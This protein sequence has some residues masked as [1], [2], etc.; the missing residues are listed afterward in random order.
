MAMNHDHPG[1]RATSRPRPLSPDLQVYRPTLT[2][3][4]SIA[5]RTTGV[6]LYIGL[7]GLVG[8]LAAV[9]IGPNAYAS[10]Q[11]MM[12]TPPGLVILF[13]F[14]WAIFH[15]VLGGI[16]HLIWDTGHAHT[17]PWREYLARATIIGSTSLAMIF[18]VAR[19][20]T[21]RVGL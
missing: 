4:M 16:R 20:W 9:A 19:Y 7:A 5:H 12:A 8:W 1:A 13:G 17:Y 15:H 6:A 10:A 2:M 18:W 11:W 21:W 3:T 14:T